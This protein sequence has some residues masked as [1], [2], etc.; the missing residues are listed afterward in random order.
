MRDDDNTPFF[1]WTTLA[2]LALLGL[3]AASEAWAQAPGSS[4]QPPPVAAVAGDKLHKSDPG[5]AKEQR[6]T[7][8]KAKRAVRRSVERAR[9][10]SAPVDATRR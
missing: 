5:V 4:S 3:L 1:H 7:V 6:S 9:T 10:G 8:R 2:L